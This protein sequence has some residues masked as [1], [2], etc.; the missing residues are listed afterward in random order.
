MIPIFIITCDRMD[1]LK[2]SIQSYYDCIKTPFKIVIVDF[3]STFKPTVEYLKGLEK[4]GTRVYWEKR[5]DVNRELNR[6]S[7]YINDYFSTHPQS[8]YVVTDPDVALDSTEGDVLDVYS[9]LLDKLVKVSVVGP[10]LRIDDIPDHYPLKE[11]VTVDS[12]HTDFHSREVH[13]IC[14]R[15]KAIRFVYAPIDT[16]FGMVKAGKQW[17]RPMRGARVLSPYS[18]RHLDWYLDPENLTEDQI[19]Y[20]EHAS[21]KVAHWSNLKSK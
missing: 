11:K 9:Y 8:N 17:I 6:L 18:A 2:K 3:G 7:F 14:Y 20:M 15:N 16:T 4:E 5:I 21:M 13:A 12:Y 10:M 1:V 19:Y